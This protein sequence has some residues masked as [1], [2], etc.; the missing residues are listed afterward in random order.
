[1]TRRGLVEFLLAR[2]SEDEAAARS[3]FRLVDGREIGGWY[4]SGAGD[5]VFVDD[6]ELPVAC[7]PW[8]QLMDQPSAHHIVRWD[9]ERVVTECAARRRVVEHERRRWRSTVLRCLAL[10]HAEH[11]DYRDDWRPR[12]RR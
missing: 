2:I 12:S 8:Q 11:P 1:V 4:W 3:A 9:P 7:G 10:V 6:S 5:A